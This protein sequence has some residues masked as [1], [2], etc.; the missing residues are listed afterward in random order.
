MGLISIQVEPWQRCRE[1]VMVWWPQHWAEVA[2]D[3]ASVPLDPDVAAYDEHARAGRLHVVTVREDGAV[4]GYHLTIVTPHL[5]YK[6]T[7]CGFVDI[8]WLRPECRRGMIGVN[9]FRE[10]E[11]SLKTR[12]VRKVYS[13]TK[14]HLDAG[15]LFEHLG[16]TEA[17]RLFSKHIG[18]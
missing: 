4:V 5:H 2:L 12:G 16:W 3:K 6:S 15:L 1:Q 14:R 8:Y 11:R 13:G 7:L 17:E 10:V 18:D 9:L